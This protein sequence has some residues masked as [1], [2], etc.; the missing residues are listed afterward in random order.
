[1]AEIELFHYRK[2]PG[3]LHDMDTGIKLICLIT[4]TVGIFHS[5]FPE[6]VAASILL[7]LLFQIEYFQSR[8]LSPAKL[9]KNIR[10][11]LLFLLFL[12]I[13]RGLTIGGTDIEHIPYLSREGVLSGIIYSW[14]LLL[15]VILGQLFTSTTDPV[16]IHGAVYRALHRLPFIN[17]GITATMVTLTITFIPL[18]FDQYLE[19]KNA[20]ESR[21]INNSRNP[22]RK[23]SS[24]A[25]PLLQTTFLRADEVTQAM[26]SRCYSDNPTLPDMK[27]RW[28]DLL[29]LFL[30]SAFL[31]IIFFVK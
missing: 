23:I 16:N 27:I 21:L 22:I 1:M 11:F 25:L 24:I 17:A 31:L 20:C 5:T 12:V 3:F 19:V 29:S 28:S 18:I 2:G 9:I 6:L 30:S 10:M 14:K 15:T 7:L 8:I 4:V 13:T 26:E